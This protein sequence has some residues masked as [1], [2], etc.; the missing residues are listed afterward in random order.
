[1]EMGCWNCGQDSS[2]SCA[3]PVH[4]PH[5]HG[6]YFAESPHHRWALEMKVAEPL[7]RA[8]WVT[9]DV[10]PSTVRLSSDDL[11]LKI[12]AMFFIHSFAR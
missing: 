10:Q 12:W 7:V 1:M 8:V 2:S 5:R 9:D 3:C 4:H 11:H 6:L